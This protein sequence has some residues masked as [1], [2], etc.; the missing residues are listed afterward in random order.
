M[1][2]GGPEGLEALALLVRLSNTSAG[3]Y[4]DPKSLVEG[5]LKARDSARSAGQYSLADE[6]RDALVGAGIDVH[7]GPEGSSW[8]LK[9]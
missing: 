5:I 2:Q 8:S 1:L 4:I 6:L 9:S 3:G 7:D